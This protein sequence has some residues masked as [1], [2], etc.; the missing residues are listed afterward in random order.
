MWAEPKMVLEKAGAAAADPEIAEVIAGSI[1]RLEAR[2]AK[3]EDRLSR[4]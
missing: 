4:S 1:D 3:V 2:L